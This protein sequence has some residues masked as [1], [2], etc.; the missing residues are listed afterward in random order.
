MT[1][2]QQVGNNAATHQPQTQEAYSEEQK[3]RTYRSKHENEP[4]DQFSNS[5]VQPCDE[6]VPYRLSV[7]VML[8]LIAVLSA[9]WIDVDPVTC[10]IRGKSIEITLTGTK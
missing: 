8:P 9:A 3:P 5:V 2:F 6:D 10:T 4:C 1:H 7:G